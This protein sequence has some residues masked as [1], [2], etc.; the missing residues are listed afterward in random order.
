MTPESGGEYDAGREALDRGPRGAGDRDSKRQGARAPEKKVNWLVVLLGSALPVG[1]IVWI[2]TMPADKR[3]KLFD[4]IPSGVAARSAAAVAA[5][6][7]MVVL[8]RLVLPG[9]K[10]AIAACLRGMAW[11]RAKK[12]VAR[13][14]LYPVEF[15][16]GLGWFL[17]QM[18]FAVDLILILACG[19]GF[20]LYAVRIVKPDLFGWLPGP[21]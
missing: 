20:L 11:C 12:G 17:M 15:V 9:A 8:A 3:Q 14:A 21:G 7:G 10:A 5:L 4:S 19:V 18:L 2:A 1:T 16:V 13:V 6:A